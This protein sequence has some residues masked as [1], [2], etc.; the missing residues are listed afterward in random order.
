[1][2]CRALRRVPPWRMVSDDQCYVCTTLATCLRFLLL[3]IYVIDGSLLTRSSL[4]I[5]T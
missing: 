4:G 2:R 1:M 5:A 3:A